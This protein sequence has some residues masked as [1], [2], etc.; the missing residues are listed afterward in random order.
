MSFVSTMKML[1]GLPTSK[2]LN[3]S[4]V[5]V[6]KDNPKPIQLQTNV[7]GEIY[8]DIYNRPVHDAEAQFYPPKVNG[9]S[10]F[11]VDAI[12]KRYKDQIIAL[13]QHV[14]IGFHRTTE[15]GINLFEA[16]YLSVIR[17]LAEY[18][19]MLPAS[20]YHHHSQPGGLFRHSL[21]AALIA[22]RK[23]DNQLPPTVGK[24]DLDAQRRIRYMYAAWVGALL[25]DTGKIL[26]D[27]QVSAYTIFD[28]EQ[29]MCVP[30]ASWSKSIKPWVPQIE[31][32]IEWATRNKVERYFVHFRASRVHKEHVS[33][34]ATLLPH[35][36]K[37]E[38]LEFIMDSPDDLYSN[39]TS[40][41]NGY[42]HINGYLATAI[43]FGD[44]VSTAKDVKTMATSAFGN[45]KKSRMM[46]IVDTMRSLK[47]KWNFNAQKG[48]AFVI[49]DCV[50]IRWQS[51]FD[52]ILKAA[53]ANQHDSLPNDTKSLLG[54][55]EDF[56]I[57][58]PFDK[59]NRFALF[60]IGKFTEKDV[61]DIIDEKISISW[62]E[63]IKVVYREWIYDSDPV[64]PNLEG[65]LYLST[66]NKYFITKEDGSF[67]ELSFDT[68]ELNIEK[69][70]VIEDTNELHDKV[71]ISPAKN[72]VSVKTEATHVNKNAG[73]TKTENTA[74]SQGELNAGKK[75][76]DT[77]KKTK[78]QK[79]KKPEKANV[80]PIQ[81]ENSSE[82]TAEQATPSAQSE[83]VNPTP[84]SERA[85]PS[86]QSEEVTPTP[87][88]EQV[89]PPALEKGKRIT[90]DYVL[91]INNKWYVDV[92]KYVKAYDTNQ[93]EAG[94]AL[95]DRGFIRQKLGSS[96]LATLVRR[97]KG[98]SVVCFELTPLG[99]S[100]LMGSVKSSVEN[101]EGLSSKPKGVTTK[102]KVTAGK[103]EL[104]LTSSDN[105]EFEFTTTSIKGSLGEILLAHKIKVAGG[106]EQIDIVLKDV[107]L[108][109][110]SHRSFIKGIRISK[111]IQLM[112]ARYKHNVTINDMSSFSIQVHIHDVSN[113][114][115]F[116]E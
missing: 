83:K 73:T 12:L 18:V 70:T 13:E 82:T 93:I 74:P 100:T 42:A 91:Q 68:T 22:L 7:T 10:V 3:H 110:D 38:G 111:L 29:N 107:A 84:Q 79:P 37:G 33:S 19:H 114:E 25:H 49:G 53:R 46:S 60:A 56:R 32:L 52:G 5:E 78:M 89:T 75:N 44:S 35:I 90:Q 24:V 115:V 21:D 97:Q 17:K 71:K 86:A 92:N 1:L 57:V 81:F 39:L 50:F 55:M 67:T 105:T 40:A 104:S 43:R 102:T 58:E 96:S 65:L 34:G 14:D 72:S 85:T 99:K 64:H 98:N 63:L 41:L 77:P 112:K 101:T 66:T 80:T 106:P 48:H 6:L 16:R 28:D 88:T 113:T 69:E 31:T 8:L 2:T 61:I 11:C 20:E 30:I 23:A 87:Q 54:M 15:D 116:S 26:T 94:Q 103:D 9:L 36:L 51:A 45:L 109:S 76:K 62:I 4:N 59:D 108:A 27:M 95:L 47:S